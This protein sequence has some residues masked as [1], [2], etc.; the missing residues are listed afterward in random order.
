[1]N[2]D[3]TLLT[4]LQMWLWFER[5]GLLTADELRALRLFRYKK[6]KAPSRFD[7]ESSPGTLTI[8]EPSQLRALRPKF[9][10]VADYQLRKHREARNATV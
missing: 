6:E 5:E 9:N 7:D 8:L 3:K 4:S 10:D 1:M 2:E